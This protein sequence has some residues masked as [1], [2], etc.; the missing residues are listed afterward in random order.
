MALTQ[1]ELTDIG[2]NALPFELRDATNLRA[3]LTEFSDIAWEEMGQHLAELDGW[4]DPDKL[5]G[6]ALSLLG[7]NLGISRPFVIIDQFFSF[8]G[9]T[10][11]TFD[12]RPFWTSESAFESR[13]SITD[14][15]YRPFL[16]WRMQTIGGS[17]TIA[18]MRRGAFNLTDGYFGLANGSISVS[19][20]T[21][22]VSSGTVSGITK[23]LWDF[24]SDDDNNVSDRLLPRIATFDYEFET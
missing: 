10:G 14:Q 18:E 21:I 15:Q 5:S 7:S 6:W 1:K 16:K 23:L 9:E 12:G 8:A 20:Q 11:A 19:G 3:L 4:P 13:Q 22:T 17:P 2:L 24:L